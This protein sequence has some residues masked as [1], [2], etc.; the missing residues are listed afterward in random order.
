MKNFLISGLA[1]AG[2]ILATPGSA[3]AH[4]GTY[5]GPGDV[6]P[7]NPGGG[8]GR[9]PGP[10]GPSTPGPGGPSTP[11]PA[12]PSTPGPSGPATG[13]PAGPGGG[14]GP[15]TGGIE[16]E[17]DLTRWEFWWEFNKDPFIN[18]K[19]AI[20]AGGVTTSSDIFFMGAGKQD[21]AKDTRKPSESQILDEILPALNRALESTDQRDITSSCL[22]AMAKIG[23]T[24]DEIDVLEICKKRLTSADQEIRETAALALGISQLTE[25]V[26]DLVA[27]TTD[28]AEGRKLV[29]R[30]SVDNR[31]RSFAAYGLGLVSWAT[32]DVDVKQKSLDALRTIL[33]DKSIN[34]RNV[35][36]AAINGISLLRPDAADP[37]G[38]E[39]L[40][41]CLTALNDYW[42]QNLGAGEQ[43]IQAHVPPAI[44][45]LY[46]GV[47][48][49][50][51]QPLAERLAKFKEEW[52]DVLTGRSK[53]QNI[54]IIQSSVVALGRTTMPNESAKDA[55]SKAERQVSETLQRYYDSGKDQQARYFSLVALGQIGGDL[56]R[57]FLLE[58]LAKGSKAIEKPWAALSLGVLAHYKYENE[59]RN[60]ERDDSLGQI[61]LRELRDQKTPGV[62]SALSIALGLVRYTDAADT[63][64]T[65]LADKQNVDDLAGYICIGLALM[66]DAEAMPQIRTLV[67]ASVRRA[68]RLQQAAIALGKLGDKEAAVLLV[69]L[70]TEDDQN[71]AKM[72]AIASALGFIGDRRT[73]EPLIKMLF[74]EG[75]TN[76]SRAF[77]AVALGGVADKELLPWNSKIGT[78]M[79]YR[80]AVETL[81]NG[82]TGILDIL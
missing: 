33:E 69:R 25:A 74:D 38:A 45:K 20:H 40:D 1:C 22:V 39:L 11:G 28:S 42:A 37:K 32:S 60:I 43:L 13:G 41:A 21:V 75:L 4:G 76:L 48:L 80:A 65:L 14:G 77:A 44:A 63:M 50:A 17:P 51:N 78:N 82:Q 24:T 58:A 12:G 26:P 81:T 19:Q 47:D 36:V 30:G 6:V 10:S 54:T 46:D 31:T 29:A 23:K 66:N 71:L 2:L 73:V 18:L 72:S 15:R 68:E 57:K 49:E 67:E 70:M 79:N 62:L 27:L 52:I 34:D 55:T 5:R 7:P 8:G 64:R 59:G 61:L 53:K 3:L 16:L 35:R 9:T 56:N